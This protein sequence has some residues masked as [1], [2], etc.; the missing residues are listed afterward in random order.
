MLSS[1]LSF[2]VLN[3]KAYPVVRKWTGD[4]LYPTY[5]P[6]KLLTANHPFIG[7]YLGQNKHS[8]LRAKEQIERWLNPRESTNLIQVSRRVKQPAFV[9]LE[10]DCVYGRLPRLGELGFGILFS[11]EQTYQNLSQFVGNYLRDSPD[12]K[13]PAT[14]SD[15]DRITQ[16]GFDLKRSFRR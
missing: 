8:D 11:P 1:V 6:W 3:G 15:R 4:K 13:P 9:M 5:R 14:V 12:L 7:F 16:H 10:R 2:C